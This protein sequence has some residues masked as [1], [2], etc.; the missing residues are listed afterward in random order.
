[1]LRTLN[2]SPFAFWIG[3][4][5]LA[6]LT[7]LAVSHGLAQAR[8]G[9]ALYGAPRP[10][11]VAVR[12]VQPGAV[13]TSADVTTRAAPAALVPPGAVEKR[14]EAE[15]RTVVVAVFAGEAVL[16]PHLAPS[17]RRGLA[18]LLPAGRQAV[19]VPTTSGGLRL[20]KGDVVDV[21]A[22]LDPP[23]PGEDPTFAVARE[24]IVLDLSGES[25]TVA[26]SPD[27]ARRVAFALAKGAVS[28][29]VTAGP[30][31]PG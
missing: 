13:L 7:G 19:A 3:V 15:G 27:E 17:G 31:S 24:A 6:A 9:A 2:R 29:A 14:S 5:G 22:T 18:A 21:L 28:L 8:A 23:P 4:G 11:V 12:G 20:R 30:S 25:V 26:V 10:V 16:R 1:M